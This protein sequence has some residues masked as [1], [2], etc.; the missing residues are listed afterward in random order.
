MYDLV[1]TLMMP[2]ILFISKNTHLYDDIQASAIKI[3]ISLCTDLIT[4]RDM[5]KISR[6]AVRRFTVK[7]VRLVLHVCGASRAL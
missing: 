6:G 4:S 7:R 5:Y 3:T 1:Q 2:A